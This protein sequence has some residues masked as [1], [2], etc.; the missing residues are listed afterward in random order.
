M[1][2][3]ANISSKL[4]IPIIF[5][6]LI[7]QSSASEALIWIGIIAYSLAVIVYLVTLPVEFD[8]SKRALQTIHDTRMLDENE[9][10][11]AKKV[12]TAAAMTY[13]ASALT[14][15]IQFL[16]LVSVVTRK[17]K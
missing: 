1:I 15:L 12:L 10:K 13:V 7:I 2:P 16:R 8:A 6:G 5:L 9:Y 17:K 3:V 4:A 11:G 14:A